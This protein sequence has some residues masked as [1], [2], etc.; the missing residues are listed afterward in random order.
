[1]IL[2]R[3]GARLSSVGS[4]YSNESSI[5]EVK[6]M[7]FLSAFLLACGD[8][9]EKQTEPE[10]V[11]EPS[12]DSAVEVPEDTVPEIEESVVGEGELYPE[13]EATYRNKNE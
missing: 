8:N 10:T 13:T 12:Q 7:L 5:W 6:M 3:R 11:L 4:Q 9:T 1:M 2:N